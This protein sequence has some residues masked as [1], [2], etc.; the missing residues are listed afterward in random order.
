MIIGVPREIKVGET[1]VSMTPNLCRRLTGLGARVVVEKG[2]GVSAG[3]SDVQ[4]R[5]AG[6]TVANQAGAVWKRADLVLKVKEPL[7]AEFPH[8]RSGLAL[9]T[10]LHLAANPQLADTLAQRRVLAIGYET[11][12]AADGTLP[13]LKPMSQIAGRLSVS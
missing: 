9:F 6:A 3:F 1:R 4:Y 12:E 2:A 7:E 13:L 8:L 5:E 10:Y 11:V